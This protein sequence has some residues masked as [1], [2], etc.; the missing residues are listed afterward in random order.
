MPL[1]PICF[2]VMPYRTKETRADPPAPPKVNFDRLWENAFQPVIQE[3]GYEPVRADQDLGALIIQEML[4]RLYFSDLVM[5]DLTIPNGNVYYEIGIRHAARKSGCV[6]V[7]AEWSKP[8]FDVDQMRQVRYPLPQE[9]TTEETAVRIRKVLKEAVPGLADGL[10]PMFQVLPGYP[11]AVQG[12]RASS[13]KDFLQQLSAFQAEVQAVRHAPKAE[14]RERA[15]AVG[16]TRGSQQPVIPAVALE[17]LYLLRDFADWQDTLTFIDALP[18][19]IRLLPVVHEQRCLA[20]S[21]TGNHLEAIGALEELV[22]AGGATSEREGLLGGRYKRLWM[23]ATDPSDKMR[24]LNLAIEHYGRG[25][26]LDLNDYFPSCNLPRLYRLR[27]KKGDADRARAAAEVARLA[28]QRSLQ[29][30][31]DDEWVRPTQLG[32]AFDAGDVTAAEELAEQV[33]QEGAAK[34]RLATTMADLELA[35]R[36]TKETETQLGLQA[37]IQT[38]KA[39]L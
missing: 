18:E 35:V 33:I 27:G 19:P 26:M 12:D 13:I 22:K 1:R 28:C 24:Y 38:L 20:Q 21:M 4:E 34:W 36:Q 7:G 37:V 10:A 15:L 14:R 30:N 2:M 25:M 11:A 23:S 29:R 39:L 5:A 32:M 31:P 6:L 16:K 9:D 3:L 17:I 8:L